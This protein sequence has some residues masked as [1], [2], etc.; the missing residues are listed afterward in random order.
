ME[1][2]KLNEFFLFSCIIFI[3]DQAG[4]FMIICIFIEKE[5]C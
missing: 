5:N 2:A 3:M 4:E 1:G